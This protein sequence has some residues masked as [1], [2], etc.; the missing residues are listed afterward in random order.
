MRLLIVQPFLA[1]YRI[2]VFE[3]LAESYEVLLA[4]EEST[5]YGGR[6]LEGLT[7]VSFS[8]L[9]NR[10]L[11]RGRLIWQSGLLKII[12]GFKPDI[13]FLSAN[14]RQL[15]LWVALFLLM[16]LESKVVLHGQGLYNKTPS[17]FYRAQFFLFSVLS[18]KYVCYT[19]SCRVPLKGMSI[20]PKTVVAENSIVNAAP[21]KKTTISENGILYIGRFRDG[22]K[23]DLLIEAVG[24]MNNSGIAIEL[25]VIGSGDKNYEKKYSSL[26]YVTFYGEIYDSAKITSISKKCFSGCYPGDA[27]LSILHYMSLSLPPIVHSCL[28]QHMGPEPSYIIDGINGIFFER[29]DKASLVIAITKIHKDK[30]LLNKLQANAFGTYQ[31]LTR[32]SLGGRI[33][34]ILNEVI[35][36]DEN[37]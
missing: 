19:D 32:P 37:S 16:F 1:K 24:S 14:P 8:R 36:V 15:S 34:K 35:S 2:P 10:G 26:S 18:D 3:E 13:V 21:F 22:C 17:L 20:Y 6:P 30:E 29:N 27:G 5:S 12:V 7:K 33:L 28:T 4:A 31:K 9:K 25:H 23:L 11:L